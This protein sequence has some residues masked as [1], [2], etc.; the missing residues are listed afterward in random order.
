MENWYREQQKVEKLPEQLGLG[1]FF[2]SRFHEVNK[3]LGHE[4]ADLLL[5]K[6]T[7]TL[8]QKTHSLPGIVAIESSPTQAAIASVEGVTFGILFENPQSGVKT[9]L[10]SITSLLAE[11]IEFDGMMI[12]LGGTAGVAIKP[13][14]GESLPDLIRNAQ[15]AIDMSIRAGQLIT[16]YHDS[17]NPYNPRRLSLA[18]ELR[19]AL[20]AG[21]TL[22]GLPA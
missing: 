4:K 21:R 16:Q 6:L 11:P 5:K 9:A 2:L 7:T 19:R 14:H 22:S 8:N 3:T 1:L 13:D 12:D 18:G 20:K 17:I 15:I 10:R